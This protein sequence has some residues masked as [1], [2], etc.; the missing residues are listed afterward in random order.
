MKHQ[1]QHGISDTD[2][3][4]IGRYLKSRPHSL[5]E[6]Q[7]AG[8]LWPQLAAHCWQKRVSGI[9]DVLSD[10]LLKDIA[11]GKVDFPALCASLKN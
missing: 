3:Q 2:L 1:A 11:Q 8:N 5:D 10:E 7:A 9:T 4:V 6:I